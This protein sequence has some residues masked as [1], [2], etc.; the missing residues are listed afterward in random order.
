[1]NSGE[2]EMRLANSPF[3]LLLFFRS[4]IPLEIVNISSTLLHLKTT[5]S[6]LSGMANTFI[7][8]VIRAGHRIARRFLSTCMVYCMSQRMSWHGIPWNRKV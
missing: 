5:P 7:A 6:M 4:M 8:L 3:F 2:N 1:M